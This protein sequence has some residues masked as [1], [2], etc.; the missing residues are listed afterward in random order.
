MKRLSPAIL[1]LA[2]VS[3]GISAAQQAPGGFHTVACI[4]VQPDKRAEFSQFSRDAVTKW[5]Q[6]RA[7]SGEIAAAYL[8]RPV[9]PRGAEQ[10]CDYIGVT[11]FPGAPPAPTGPDHLTGLLRKAGIAMSGEEFVARRESVSR[12]VSLEMWRTVIS[13]G[14]V[15]KGDYAYVN[16]MKVH[17]VPE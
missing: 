8:F 9:L 15:E 7:D 6:A 2:A 16:F 17:D 5:M 1:A 14:H 11:V 13:L 4:K 3:A 12:L 10:P